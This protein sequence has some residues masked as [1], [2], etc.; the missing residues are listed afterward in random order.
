MKI[1]FPSLK[2]WTGVP[3]GNR[4]R[5]RYHTPSAAYGY[6][7]VESLMDEDLQVLLDEVKAYADD[8]P[9]GPNLITI[10]DM[11][12]PDTN[13]RWVIGTVIETAYDRDLIDEI[14]QAYLRKHSGL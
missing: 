3:S 11:L 5:F 8:K 6:L 12:G 9:Y 4:D 7:L 10:K 14:D 2:D 13:P 1:N